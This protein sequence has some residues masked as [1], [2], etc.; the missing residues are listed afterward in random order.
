MVKAGQVATLGAPAAST[1]VGESNKETIASDKITGTTKNGPISNEFIFL[2]NQDISGIGLK[3][4]V[5]EAILGVFI[6][7]IKPLANAVQ[8]DHHWY[9]WA[10]RRRDNTLV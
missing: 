5:I 10:C 8:A 4:L 3:F 1:A 7:D 2:I 9:I 6:D